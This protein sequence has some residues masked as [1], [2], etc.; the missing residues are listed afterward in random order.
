MTLNE[1]A[2]KILTGSVDTKVKVWDS[3]TVSCKQTLAGHKLAVISLDVD[4]SGTCKFYDNLVR[5]GKG[6]GEDN[7]Y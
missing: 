3:E 7:A 6:R 4:S 5:Y 2:N 1:T